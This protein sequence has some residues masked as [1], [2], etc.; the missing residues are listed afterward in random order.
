MRLIT[1]TPRSGTAYTSHYLNQLGIDSGHENPGK[2]FLVS[3]MAAAGNKDLPFWA[4]SP[5]LEEFEEIWLVV[6]DPLKTIGSIAC[7]VIRPESM[8]FAQRHVYFPGAGIQ[9][10]IFLSA[11]FWYANWMNLCKHLPLSRYFHIEKIEEELPGLLLEAGYSL[12]GD[13]RPRRDLSR[14]S[15]G[16][17]PS[18]TWG[19]L[20]RWVPPELFQTVAIY[21]ME[22]GY[23]QD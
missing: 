10:G 7:S 17:H 2:D 15:R 21:A 14:N 1:G 12:P 18:P 4:S 9:S 3:W 16:E 19:E 20:R 5:P 22:F 8:E 6:R 11:T 23:E 13:T